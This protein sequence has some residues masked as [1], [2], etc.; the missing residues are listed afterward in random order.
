VEEGYFYFTA[1]HA[2]IDDWRRENVPY[3]YECAS[4]V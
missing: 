4:V 1:K 3:Y 2:T